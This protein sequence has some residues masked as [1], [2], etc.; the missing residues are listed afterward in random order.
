MGTNMGVAPTV[1]LGDGYEVPFSQLRNCTG[2][3]SGLLFPHNCFEFTTPPGEGAG[4]ALPQYAPRG[5]TWVLKA[6]NQ[7]SI[8]ILYRHAAPRV[9]AIRSEVSSFP[10]QGGVVID[11]LGQ[12][13]GYTKPGR[14]VDVSVQLR[15]GTDLQA[16]TGVSRV[17]HGL[18]TCTLPEGSGRNLEILVTVA[19]TASA[20]NSVT[21]SY[22][23]PVILNATTVPVDPITLQPIFDDGWPLPNYTSS[24]PSWPLYNASYLLPGSPP[25]VRAQLRGGTRGNDTVIVTTGVNL[26]RW[27]P[28]KHCVCMSDLRRRA[29]SITDAE[30]CQCNNREDYLGEGEVPDDHIL[31]WSH[32]SIMFRP[33]QG[34]GLKE[35]QLSI[36]GNGLGF[37]R[38]SPSL[39]NFA[40]EPPRITAIWPSVLGTDGGARVTLFGNN[41]GPRPGN[42]SAWDDQY[43]S[44]LF[45]RDG[46]DVPLSQ[47]P[48][49]PTAFLKIRFHRAE[50]PSGYDVDGSVPQELAT[51]GNPP[52]YTYRILSWSHERITFEAPP[53]IGAN[54]SASISVLIGRGNNVV[55]W[56][57][58]PVRFSYAPPQV[59]R[60]DP[61][62]VYMTTEPR[63]FVNILGYNFGDDGKADI[64]GW[65][66]EERRIGV[67]FNSSACL[68]TQR[69]REGSRIHISCLVSV[70]ASDYNVYLSGP[71]RFGKHPRL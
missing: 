27:D 21:F 62:I 23:A 30:V 20:N 5:F 16:C 52:D 24:D 45:S 50:I 47:A 40:Y 6:G 26:G 4:V 68:S 29:I 22:D 61:S 18:I 49:L 28:T 32:N 8:R 51:N 71:W 46:Y 19:G 43:D 54:R 63:I 55:E 11:I 53:G 65:T 35:I 69:V 39:Y 14:D 34:V 2:T 64:Q 57:S 13:F 12:N 31:A 58:A 25:G 33:N 67:W 66:D 59:E 48:F 44:D 3:A 56:R 1:A 10:T 7:D 41:F 70:D 37:P 42:F 9:A 15:R 17:D 36:R 60:A 38:G